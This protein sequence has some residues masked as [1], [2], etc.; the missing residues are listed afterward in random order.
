[1]IAAGFC[2]CISGGAVGALSGRSGLIVCGV[3]GASFSI[4]RARLRT[5]VTRLRQPYSN[6]AQPSRVFM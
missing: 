1:M 5:S 4:A 6:V 3:T 2:F